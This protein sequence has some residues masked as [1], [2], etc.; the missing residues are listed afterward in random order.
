M[1]NDVAVAAKAY[2]SLDIVLGYAGPAEI[3]LASQPMD[4]VHNSLV[5]EFEVFLC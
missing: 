3:E 5:T 4:N 1:K 2:S